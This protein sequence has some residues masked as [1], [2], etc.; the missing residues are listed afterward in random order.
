MTGKGGR[1]M[2]AAFN[3]VDKAIPD[4]DRAAS[5]DVATLEHSEIQAALR[6]GDANMTLC[7]DN[8]TV[9]QLIS[10]ILE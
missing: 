9:R 2:P 1:V 10:I 4:I 5:I 6:T 3:V 8:E 7:Y